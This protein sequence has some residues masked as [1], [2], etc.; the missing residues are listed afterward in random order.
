MN[1]ATGS[2]VHLEYYYFLLHNMFTLDSELAILDTFKLLCAAFTYMKNIFGL[3]T[4]SNNSF[5]F[6][7]DELLHIHLRKEVKMNKK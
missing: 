4:T 7:L 5:S 3:Y 1:L 2:F 6:L